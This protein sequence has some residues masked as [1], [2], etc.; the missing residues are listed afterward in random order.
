M[1]EV[2]PEQIDSRYRGHDHLFNQKPPAGTVKESQDNDSKPLPKGV[3]LDKDGKP[4]VASE[5]KTPIKTETSLTTHLAVAPARPS[6]HGA[7]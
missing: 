6:P 3:V 2:P 5:I 7:P 1:A 4:Y